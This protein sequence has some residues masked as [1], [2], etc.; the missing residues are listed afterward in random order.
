MKIAILCCYAPAVQAFLRE[1]VR[2]LQERGHRVTVLAPQ[3]DKAFEKL[4]AQGVVCYP[5]A[6]D[7]GG[8]NPLS[9]LA[10]GRDVAQKL[11]QIRPDTVL[12]FQAKAVA[13]GLPAARR[14]GV[15]RRFAMITGIGSV[16]A[17]PPQGFKARL[18]RLVLKTLY[19]RALRLAAAVFFE[20]RDN[21]SLFQRWRLV[22]EKQIRLLPGIGVD[23]HEFAFAPMPERCN[24]LFIGRYNRDKGLPEFLRAARDLRGEGMDA[25]FWVIGGYD[26]NPTALT[27]ADIAPYAED[28]SVEFLGP[29]PDVRPF[30]AG[31]CAFVLPSHH[32]GTPK[33]ILEAMATGRPIITTHAPGCRERVW[34]GEN[35]FLVPIG[36]VQALKDACRKLYEN[37]ALAAR[38]GVRGRE[39]CAEKFDVARVTALILKEV[40][41]DYGTV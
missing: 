38:M 18:M 27:Q 7:R 40:A 14:A 16:L 37:P 25:R 6:L 20:N 34:E 31:C 22:K 26:I 28:E 36:D 4:E 41:V 39:I 33:V 10:G 23:L 1:T 12:C 2:E 30:L 13:Y 11:R 8:T 17:N 19:R 5:V 3:D 35:G 21:A 32:E 15:A 24:F 9:D 29:Q